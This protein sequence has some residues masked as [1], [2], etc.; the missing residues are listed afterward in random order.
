[1]R[2]GGSGAISGRGVRIGRGPATLIV[3]RRADVRAADA[4]GA[5]PTVHVLMH[6]DDGLRDAADCAVPILAAR[7]FTATFFLVAGAMGTT[8][9]WTQS[10]IG[11]ASKII[12]WP[13]ARRLESA[14][15]SCG[16]GV[17]TASDRFFHRIDR[18]CNR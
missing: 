3:F 6:L 4:A 18:W 13:T 15:L 10:E 17:C 12:N 1:M 2:M 16:S 8:S 11:V 7:R 14:G 9:R 5:E